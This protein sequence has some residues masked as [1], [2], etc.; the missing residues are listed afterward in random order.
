MERSQLRVSLVCRYTAKSAHCL[1]PQQP[2][3]Q[4]KTGI[5]LFK[6][7]HDSGT[8]A[9]L[10]YDGSAWR[11]QIDLREPSQ[12]PATIVRKNSTISDVSIVDGTMTKPP[13]L[14]WILGNCRN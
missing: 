10:I 9:L 7:V 8:D 14:N 1:I 5:F 4:D 12:D 6:R 13:I 3:L 11:I 2:I